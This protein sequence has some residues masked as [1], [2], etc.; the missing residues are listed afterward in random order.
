MRDTRDAGRSLTAWWMMTLATM[1]SGC[2]FGGAAEPIMTEPVAPMPPATPPPPPTPPEVL[3]SQRA[4][5]VVEACVNR[6]GSEAREVRSRY[7]SV[8]SETGPHGDEDLDRVESYFFAFPDAAVPACR[9]AHDRML[10]SPNASAELD[11]ASTS[12][13]TTLE[14]LAPLVVEARTYY[15]RETFLDDG[16]AGASALH[17][18]LTAALDAFLLAS[19]QLHLVVS[20]LERAALDLRLAELAAD[21]ARRGEYLVERAIGMAN[22]MISLADA[23][24]VEPVDDGYRIVASDAA[25]FDAAVD[26]YQQAADEMIAAPESATIDTGGSYRS[27]ARELVAEAIELRRAVET[28]RVFPAGEAGAAIRRVMN[29]YN[30]VVDAYNRTRR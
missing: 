14:T 22:A 18:R 8:V 25:A 17:P 19:D 1:A 3:A 23:L 21:P 16:G 11:A 13:V 15:E 9:A 30:Q 29:K 10:A 24:E 27:Y 7:L 2:C 12:Y 4:S 5:L 28:G 26:A 6:F 20:R